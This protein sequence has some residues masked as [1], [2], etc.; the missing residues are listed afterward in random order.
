MAD[1]QV[2]LYGDDIFCDYLRSTRFTHIPVK[3]DPNIAP[4]RPSQILETLAQRI[5]LLSTFSIILS[6]THHHAD[7]PHPIG[8]LPARRERPNCGRATE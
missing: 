2:R 4:I 8:L 3:I 1:D 6:Q 7:A 5:G